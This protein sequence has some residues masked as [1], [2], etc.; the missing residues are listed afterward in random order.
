[1]S[2]TDEP[3][4]PDRLS[5]PT[6]SGTRVSRRRMIS[7]GAGTAAAVW[8]APTVVGFGPRAAAQASGAGPEFPF[9]SNGAVPFDPPPPD[10]SASN[11]ATSS[12]TNTFVF[13]E[14][15]CFVLT[16][17]LTVNRST[18]GVNF[19]GNTSEGTTIASGTKICSYFVHGDRD[20]IPGR[21]TGT[22]TFSTNPV[23]GLIYRSG[24]LTDSNFLAVTGVNYDYGPTEANDFITLDLTPGAN[25]V[26]WNMRFGGVTDQIRIITAC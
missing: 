24:E 21:L 14:A 23:L 15:Q 25:S 20:T 3:A 8:I 12:N 10:L 11:P 17:D 7:A 4:N 22:A 2:T 1:M 26:S 5:G 13:A 9:L 19:P 6:A 16:S 18:A